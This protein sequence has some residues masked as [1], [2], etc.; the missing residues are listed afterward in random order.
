MTR[1]AQPR[2]GSYLT[3]K[4][5]GDTYY[6]TPSRAKVSNYCS[7][8]CSSRARMRIR[9]C[10]R[11]GAEVRGQDTYCGQKCY[12]DKRREEREHERSVNPPVEEEIGW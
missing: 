7:L 4:Q 6:A 10:P 1:K 8:S 3:C 11:C 12:L 9:S 2:T 5:C